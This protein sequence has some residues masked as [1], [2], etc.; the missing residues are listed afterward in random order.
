L[1][2]ALDRFLQ[3]AY[4]RHLTDVGLGQTI[5]AACV[6]AA[7]AILL[8]VVGTQILDWYWPVLLFAGSFGAGLYR[9]RKRLLTRYQIAQRVDIRL[10]LQDRLSTAYHFRQNG[11]APEAALDRIERQIEERVSDEDLAR[12]TP[13]MLP[14]AAYALAG[15]VMAMGALLGVR[16]GVMRSLDLHAPIA[17][18]DFGRFDEPVAEAA[19]RKT[20]IQES[21]EKQLQ[22]LGLSM[23]DLETPLAD[24][25]KTPQDTVT[26]VSA[27]GNQES[28]DQPQ[29]GQSTGEKAKQQ[30]EEGD[31]AEGSEGNQT[32]SS[33]EANDKN[34]ENQ[35]ASQNQGKPQSQAPNGKNPPENS[36]LMDKMKD[37]LANLMQKLK[38]SPKGKEAQ[39]TASSAQGDSQ[40]KGQQQQKGQSQSKTQGEGQ[41]SPD[42]QGDREGDGADQTQASANKPG[43][44][45][46][47]RPGS[48]DAKSGMGKQDGSKEIR[49]AE[50]LAAMGKISEILGKRAAQIS[51]EMSIEVPSGKQQ[52]KTAYSQK[53]ALHLDSG[54]EVHRDEIPLIYQTYVQ[55]YFEEVR[56]AQPK[57]N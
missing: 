29:E 26:T 57:K 27:P 41:P 32:A 36:N 10:G 3:R 31:Q 38:T 28:V 18:I 50:Q 43:D 54:G 47:D 17:R 42:Q 33:G 7:G 34:Q 30:Q 1:T 8:L 6:G 13:I 5:V 55:R 46:A 23:E 14:K 15:L 51:G 48:E 9:A 49:D 56:K 53:R 11:G 16:Y 40:G 45:S 52:L 2:G 44:K 22:Q 35:G 19:T 4:R 24:G 25:D 12:A 21:F 39:Q 20:A 37:A